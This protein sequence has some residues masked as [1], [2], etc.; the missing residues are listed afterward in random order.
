M[1]NNLAYQHS[2]REELI[3]GNI[4]MMSP[5]STGHNRLAL[6]I[7]VVFENYLKGRTCIPFGDG[8]AVFLD[9]KNHFIPD[10][11]VVCDRDKIKPNWV[12]GAPDLVWEVLS[13]RTAKN[14]RW[15]KK[16]AYEAGGVPEYWIVDPAG[17]SVEV[18]LLEEGRYVLDDIYTRYSADA[19]EAMT[20]EEKAAIAWE[21]RCHLYSDL[22]I[23]LED[24][25]GD[26]L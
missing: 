16:N 10:G 7:A 23:R 8:T 26:L 22:S 3:N 1:N 25:F 19:L 24:I 21:F 4:V 13:P 18:Y 14:D 15:H 9:D 2:D 20:E 5:A 11:M 6:R 12:E 17:Q